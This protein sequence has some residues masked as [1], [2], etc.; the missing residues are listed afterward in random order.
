MTQVVEGTDAALPTHPAC[1]PQ[2]CMQSYA[3]TLF[4]QDLAKHHE[5]KKGGGEGGGREWGR[6]LTFRIEVKSFSAKQDWRYKRYSWQFTLLCWNNE[7]WVVGADYLKW[8]LWAFFIRDWVGERGGAALPCALFLSLD[9][10]CP[11]NVPSRDKECVQALSHSEVG[12]GVWSLAYQGKRVHSK[13]D[14]LK[15]I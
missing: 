14:C 3:Y 15:R 10:F 12:K 7:I 4:D 9:N 2:A 11:W 13:S 6:R 1:S 5:K 8:A